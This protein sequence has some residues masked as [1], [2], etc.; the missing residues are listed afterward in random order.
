M[1]PKSI[2]LALLPLIPLTASRPQLSYVA[3]G[4]CTYAGQ[5]VC[6]SSSSFAL[7]DATL[8]GIIQP[9]AAGDNRCTGEPAVASP[10]PAAASSAPDTPA[11]SAPAPTADTLAHVPPPSAASNPT[12]APPAATPPPAAASPS[13]APS[14]PFLVSPIPAPTASPPSAT[15]SNAFPNVQI[16]ASL[17]KPKPTTTVAPAVVPVTRV[18]STVPNATPSPTFAHG[19]VHGGAEPGS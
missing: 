12:A 15:T 16:L 5:L 14:A 18:S 8:H 2:L 6:V 7:C 17:V 3:N 13:A 1:I 4:A 10:P 9:L 19:S 11:P